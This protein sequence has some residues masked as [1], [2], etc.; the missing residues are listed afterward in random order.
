VFEQ[1]PAG[2]I[3][4]L[5]WIAEFIDYEEFFEHFPGVLPLVWTLHDMNP[6]TGGCHYA[7]E[8]RKFG[9]ECGC[10]P[11][12]GSGKWND[13]SRAIWKRK[14]EAYGHID[15][16]RFCVVTPSQWLA[17]EAK[18]SALLGGF[19]IEVIPYGVD[20]N[21]FRPQ[22]RAMARARLGIAA[23]ATVVL[24]V[25]QSLGNSYKGMPVLMEALQRAERIPN[26]LVVAVGG[27]GLPAGFPVECV[28]LGEMNEEK[29][30]ALA[31]SAS[32]LFVLPSLQDNFPNT[33]LEAMA[34][35][36]PVVGTRVGG[37]PEIVRD[38]C[39]G[40]L[41]EQGDAAALAGAIEEL[42]TNA[43]WRAEMAGNCRRVALEEYT[44][45]MQTRRYVGV[46]ESLLS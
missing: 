44:L 7:G 8:C 24:F 9:E 28:S 38:G 26:L 43:E 39:T 36:V 37:I 46:Y 30:L 5:H 10:C 15:G 22:E 21:C 25:A 33:A 16:K 1:M 35:G 40:R 27:G 11:Q 3:L 13:L 6:F 29:E 41:V 34:C 42:L 45:E 18:R 2:D 19:R 4:H 31:Y 17:D 32:D 14:R 23:E 12:L 20:T